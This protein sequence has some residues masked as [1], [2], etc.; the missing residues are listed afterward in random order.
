MAATA[1]DD[2]P[3]STLARSWNKLLPAVDSTEQSSSAEGDPAVECEDLARQLD[4]GLQEED[5]MEWMDGNSDDQGYQLLSDDDI[6]RQVTQSDEAT[7]EDEEDI[8]EEA[9]NIPGS[10]EVKD[11]LD[12]CLLWYERQEDSTSTSL[13]LLKRIRDLA[14]TKRFTNL[15][16]LKLDSFYGPSE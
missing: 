12:K 16:Q 9:L 6:I 14:A 10:G 8:N 15:K 5:I 3:S 13:L 2:L 11:M 1:W 4:S 7:E